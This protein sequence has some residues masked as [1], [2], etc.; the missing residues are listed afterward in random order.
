M[1]AT[2]CVKFNLKVYASFLSEFPRSDEIY[3]APSGVQKERISPEDMF[4][5]NMDG[6]DL[7]MPPD[8]KK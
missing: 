7:V 2:K 4:V 1:Q 3:I 5:Q 8:Y 6:D